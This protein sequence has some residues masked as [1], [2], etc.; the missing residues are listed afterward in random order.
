MIHI[1]LLPFKAQP[2]FRKQLSVLT[3]YFPSSHSSLHPLQ[4]GF[5]L[6]RA[7]KTVQAKITN[8]PHVSKIPYNSLSRKS[9]NGFYDFY[10]RAD[11]V[12]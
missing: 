8:D 7:T 5:H 12:L 10:D 3:V 2:N 6:H 9:K 4:S 1:S 11:H